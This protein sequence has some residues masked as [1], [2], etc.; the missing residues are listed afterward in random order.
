[1]L[2]SASQFFLDYLKLFAIDIVSR[3]KNSFQEYITYEL[4]CCMFLII[5]C[6]GSNAR[7][8]NVNKLQCLF[9]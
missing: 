7:I 2:P 8:N 6:R 9:I 5:N 1:M 4:Y 3:H